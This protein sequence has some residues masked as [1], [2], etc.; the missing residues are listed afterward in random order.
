[1]STRAV[2][3]VRAPAKGRPER[4]SCREGRQVGEEDGEED[5]DEDDERRDWAGKGPEEQQVKAEAEAEL[6]FFIVL[7]FCR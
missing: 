1:M 4:A 7:S 3:Q 2:R 5:D 6:A